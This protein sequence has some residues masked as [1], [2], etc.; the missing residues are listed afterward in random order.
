MGKINPLKIMGKIFEMTQE[1]KAN[2]SLPT[3]DLINQANS[4][5]PS[6]SL[7]TKDLLNQTNPASLGE[8]FAVRNGIDLTR[9]Q[10]QNPTPLPAGKKNKDYDGALVGANGR[11]YSS[12][13]PLSQIPTVEPAGGRKSNEVIIFVNGINTDFA[14]HNKNLQNIANHTGQPVIGVYNATEGMLKDLMQSAGDKYDIGNNPAVKTMADNI[15]NELKAG[16]TIHLMAHSQGGLIT[17]RA[18]QDVQNRLRLED[19]MSKA[20][21]QKLMGNVKVETFGSAA[22]KYP[23][24]PKYVHYVNNKDLVP[25]LFG[26][27]KKPKIPWYV[28]LAAYANPTTAPIMA[29]IDI[30]KLAAKPGIHA[31][32][33]AQT[34][35]FDQKGKGLF[36]GTHTF[37]DAYLPRR[38]PF[39]QAY[40]GNFRR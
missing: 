21:A 17:S 2:R 22:S 33:G 5:T 28:R 29:F 3:K 34:H 37:D 10:L 25:G 13:T 11:A 35:Y 14:G 30:A 1:V 15:Y 39:D 27:G 26:L 32:N 6:R 31:G 8:G 23:D 38:V 36:E 4:T 16:R 40:Q 19:G 24:G 18:L 20:D 9:F 7:P 12:N